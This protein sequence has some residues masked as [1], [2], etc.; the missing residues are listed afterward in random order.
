MSTTTFTLTPS[1]RAELNQLAAV[2]AVVT[3]SGGND[4]GGGDITYLDADGNEIKVESDYEAGPL[5]QFLWEPIED[6]YGGFGGDFSAHGTLT[7]DF[8][9]MVLETEGQETSYQDAW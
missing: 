2:K 3:Y 4:E 7:Y 8:T 9:T 6:R 1:L 5:G